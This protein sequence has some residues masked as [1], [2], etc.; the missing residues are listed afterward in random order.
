MKDHFNTETG[1]YFLDGKYRGM[2]MSSMIY[3]RGKF[4]GEGIGHRT[5]IMV[6]YLTDLANNAVGK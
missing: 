2:F 4:E 1:Q 6:S 3:L 5:D